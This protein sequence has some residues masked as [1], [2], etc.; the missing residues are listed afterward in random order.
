MLR[1]STA[2]RNCALIDGPVNTELSSK[3]AF[4]ISNFFAVLVL[5]FSLILIHLDN[6]N[7][8]VL[9]QM[10]KWRNN[11]THYFYCFFLAHF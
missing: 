8:I 11:T 1:K 2:I 4:N 3:L 5:E 9:V 7:Q 10:N 6:Y